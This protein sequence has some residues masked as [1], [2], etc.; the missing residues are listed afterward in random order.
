M[1]DKGSSYLIDHLLKNTDL[2][3]FMENEIGVMFTWQ[4]E[5]TSASCCC[6]MPDHLDT[7]A[8][9]RITK[10]NDVFIYHCLSGDTRVV[11]W[12]GV[13]PIKELSGTEQKILTE[14]GKWVT[15]PFSCF[16]KQSLS[17]IVLTRNQ[18]EKT[19]YATKEHR[20]FLHNKK[21]KA[22]V[23]TT[24]ELKLNDSLKSV[25]PKKKINYVKQISP[26]GIGH[27]IFFGDGTTEINSTTLRLWGEK[28]KQLEKWFPLNR[29]NNIK[30]ASGVEGISVH[31][32][33]RY[34]KKRPPLNEPTSYLCGF[35]AGWLAADGHVA[36]DGTICLNS[37][38][39]ENLEFAREIATRIGIGTYGITTQTRIGIDNKESD[40]HR[41]HFLNE[42]MDEKMFLIKTHKERFINH[43]KKYSRKRWVVKDIT[44]DVKTELVYCA[45]VEDTH[46]FVLED[47]I[48]TGNCFGCGAKGNI[49]HFCQDYFNLRSKSESIKFICE[50]L[51]IQDIGDLALEGLKNISKKVDNQ[52]AIE[53]SNILVSNQC[54]MLLRKDYAK[55][56]KWVSGAFKRI[57]AALMDGDQGTVEEIGNEA[58]G[59]MM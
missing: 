18:Q 12:D 39:K 41:I 48:L 9:F 1:Q 11:T 22:Y 37:H 40:I 13:K 17:K 2:T 47:N 24:D 27:G 7:N 25:F 59:R 55:H 28:D 19:I 16:G 38:K 50:K 29:K 23:R 36:K 46:S 3:Q 5:D 10:M 21:G 49:I 54:R 45:Y 33:P 51:N 26:Q 6:P 56:S 43:N 34:Y 20:W 57:N 35:L 32:L 31:N 42:S 8:S 52:R 15:A 30:L 4:Q 44:H 58:F 53:N 14:G